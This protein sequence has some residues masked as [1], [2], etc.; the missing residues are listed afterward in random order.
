MLQVMKENPEL[1][2]TGVVLETSENQAVVLLQRTERCHSCT[3]CKS[4]PDGM[5]LEVH[6]PIGVSTGAKVVIGRS[7]QALVK[8]TALVFVLPLIA[9]FAGAFAAQILLPNAGDL[10]VASGAGIGLV[11]GGVAVWLYERNM[12]AGTRQQFQPYIERIIRD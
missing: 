9:L 11:L 2:E 6:D 3:L 8:A 10:V 12:K 7:P 4:G 5:L 1:E